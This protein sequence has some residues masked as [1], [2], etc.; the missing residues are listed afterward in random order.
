MSIG[1]YSV[2]FSL[3]YSIRI[4]LERASDL[5]LGSRN[6]WGTRNL[7]EGKRGVVSWRSIRVA[8]YAFSPEL[9]FSK[10][11]RAIMYTEKTRVKMKTNLI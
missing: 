11:R 7:S 4:D 1:S 8:N 6:Y 2:S 5:C 3:L 10:R 9:G